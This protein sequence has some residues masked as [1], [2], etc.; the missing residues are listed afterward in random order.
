MFIF[1]HIG[2]TLGAA[3]LVSGL[4]AKCHRPDTKPEPEPA[5]RVQ[6]ISEE[7]RDFSEIIGLKSLA[8]F[9][10]IRL[11]ILGSLFPDILDK[12][13]SFLG[14][15]DGRSITHTLLITVIVLLAS[16]IIFRR[17]KKTWLLAIAFGMIAHI[18]LDS[19]WTSPR[20]LLWPLY[21]WEFPAPDRSLNQIRV[22]WNILMTNP[23][24]DVSEA[25]GIVIILV[26]T[27]ILWFR[28]K[29]EAFITKG[30]I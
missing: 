12:P 24:V 21:G 4:V 15:G 25:I 27:G 14:F 5:D 2:I 29:F 9:L 23:G 1:A 3:T 19:M 13:L 28:R 17:Y 18:I 26:F 22:W 11:L 6:N 7:K 20:T 8:K 10:D 16:L 30:E